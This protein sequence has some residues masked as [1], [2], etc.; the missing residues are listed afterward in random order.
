[1]R[2]SLHLYSLLFIS[3][4]LLNACGS[5]ITPQQE[6][7]LGEQQTRQVLQ[8]AKLS[9]NPAYNTHVKRVS[10]RIASVA[11]R[12]DFHWQYY[13]LE[14]K[15]P[16]AFV[17]P[18]GKIFVNSGLFRYVRSDAELATVISHEIA[19]ALRSH[20][21]EGAQRKQNASL[22]GAL[23]QVGMGVAGVDP[24]IAQSVTQAYGYGATYGY[25][26]PYS[27]EKEAEAD[28]IGLML[29]AKAGYDPR[30]ALSFWKK[31]AKQGQRVPEFFSTHPSTSH[32]I[33]NLKRLMPQAV[34][35]YEKSIRRHRHYASRR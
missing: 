32:R 23:L 34:A 2:H 17:L 26:R 5:T 14:N 27:R 30:A 13:V 9:K 21:I 1:M 29:M 25:I 16:N 35:L 8:K 15:T 31:F 7:A 24:S 33:A 4:L 18:G 12:H 11:N 28:A 10:R 6:R 19:H 20:G 22:V 3:V